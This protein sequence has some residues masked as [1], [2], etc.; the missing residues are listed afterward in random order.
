MTDANATNIKKS[1]LK[2]ATLLQHNRN[3]YS[4]SEGERQQK[5]H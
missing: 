3:H 5:K 4:L 2:K 1:N